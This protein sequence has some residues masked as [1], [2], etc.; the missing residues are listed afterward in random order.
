MVEDWLAKVEEYKQKFGWSDYTTIHKVL[1][2]LKDMKELYIWFS[3]IA[4]IMD[5]GQWKKKLLLAFPRRNDYH[6][7][8]KKMIVRRKKKE[9]TYVSYYYD[10][11]ALF[12]PLELTDEQKVSCIFGGITDVLVCCVGRVG[13]Y[14]NPGELLDYFK[15]CDDK[16]TVVAA[17]EAEKEARLV[18]KPKPK[19]QFHPQNLAKLAEKKKKIKCFDCHRMGHTMAE[20]RQYNIG[21]HMDM[22]DRLKPQNNPKMNESRARRPPKPV[23]ALLQCTLCGKIGHIQNTC[24][25]QKKMKL[26]AANNAPQQK[27]SPKKQKEIVGKA[28]CT[29]ILSF[30]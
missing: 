4:D 1:V 28:D 29:F 20:C 19:A 18:A 11:V 14:K 22:V 2:K 5:W 10:K 9:E 26:N 21:A 15:S 7:H 25:L 12:E 23:K 27:Q 8:L 17:A 30:A 3:N 24:R 6:I 16:Q 13:D